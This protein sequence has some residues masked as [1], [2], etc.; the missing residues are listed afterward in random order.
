MYLRFIFYILAT[1]IQYQITSMPKRQRRKKMNRKMMIVLVAIVA[2]V[3]PAVAVA[4]VMITGSVT[5]NGSNITPYYFTTGPNYAAANAAGVIT[6]TP[7]SS[8]SSMGTVDLEGV[9]NQSVSMVNVGEFVYTGTA[10]GTFYFNFTG[11]FPTGAY[12]VFSSSPIT[13]SE[14][15]SAHEV[16]L[17]GE[18]S[19]V[20]PVTGA[21]TFYLS[22]YLPAGSYVTSSGTSLSF[23]I[24]VSFVS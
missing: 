2:T 10:S 1:F 19:A 4:D 5:V 9:T 11:D 8:G 13:L 3:L 20:A 22:F 23:N 18:Y 6:W 16:P 12:A 14:L 17:S 7:S 24:Q 21:S 15:S